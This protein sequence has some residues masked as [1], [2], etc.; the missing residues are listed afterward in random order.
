MCTAV[1][2]EGTLVNVIAVTVPQPK[3]AVARAETAVANLQ[4]QPPQQPRKA[5]ADN[6]LCLLDRGGGRR[7][8]GGQLL[9]QSI[10]ARCQILR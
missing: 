4:V 1:Q 9:N 8:E 6:L 10:G 5:I 2:V 7:R 3:D